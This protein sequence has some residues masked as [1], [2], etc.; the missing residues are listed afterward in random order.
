MSNMIGDGVR[1]F[2]DI[3]CYTKVAGQFVITLLVPEEG[4]KSSKLPGNTKNVDQYF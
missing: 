1:S 4:L 3:F 2:I